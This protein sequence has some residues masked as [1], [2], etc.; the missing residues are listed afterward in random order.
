MRGRPWA[1]MS[2]HDAGLARYLAAMER[3][4]LEAFISSLSLRGQARVAGF[5]AA[6]ADESAPADLQR[7]GYGAD[8]SPFYGDEDYAEGYRLGEAV[9][10]IPTVG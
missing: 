3:D 6:V 7:P 2:V 10:D 1:S 8:A 4:S 5:L 9:C